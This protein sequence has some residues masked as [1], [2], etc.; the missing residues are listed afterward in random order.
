MG[1]IMPI[2]Q[3]DQRTLQ[4][5]RLHYKLLEDGVEPLAIARMAMF[6]CILELD[7]QGATYSQIIDMFTE[8]L[9]K[10][11]ETT[12]EEKNEDIIMDFGKE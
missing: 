9:D 5:L 8:F 1:E 10:F 6:M 11:S 7:T 4:L 3:I 2:Q 12:F